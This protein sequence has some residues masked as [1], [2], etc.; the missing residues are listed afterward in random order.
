M[1]NSSR[2]CAFFSSDAY[3]KANKEIDEH[4]RANGYPST[5]KSARSHSPKS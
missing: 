5:S 1:P 2:V 4:L 3:A